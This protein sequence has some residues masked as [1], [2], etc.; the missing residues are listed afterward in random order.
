[1]TT[2]EIRQFIDA[3]VDRSEIEY[4]MM[5]SEIG[6]AFQDQLIDLLARG[7]MDTY[8]AAVEELVLQGLCGGRNQCAPTG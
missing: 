2:Q 4:I 3:G 5:H 1:M 8:E 6:E 7:D